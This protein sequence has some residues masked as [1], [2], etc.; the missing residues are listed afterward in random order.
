MSEELA[1]GHVSVGGDTRQ[2]A[3]DIRSFFARTEK[4]SGTS[5]Q[6]AGNAFGSK[7]SQG[8][9]SDRRGQ[10][11]GDKF[12]RGFVRGVGRGLK[13][14]AATFLIV[15][16]ATRGV[17]R[18][19][20]GIA[21]G[22]TLATRA[23]RY[24][25][26]ALLAGSAG[27]RMIAGV[28]FAKLAGWLKTLSRLAGILARDVGR[29]AAMFTVL[30]AAARTLGTAMRVTRVIGMLTVG[31]AT[32]IG[33]ASTAG[34]A[35][36]AL[37]GAIATLGSAAAGI[38]VA[39][40]SAFG[41]ALAGM[42]L[43]LSGMGDAFKA[44]GKSASGGGSAAAS[45]AKQVA[46]AQKQLARAVDDEKE[47]QEDVSKAREDARKKL[48]SLDRQLRGA[49]T[50]EK[51]AKLDL[52]DAQAELAKGDFANGR[53][54]A[55][56][57][58]AVE[59]AELELQN[60][61]ADNAD[62]VKEAADMRSKGVEGSDEVTAAQKRLYQATEATKEAQDAL[63]EARKPQDSGGGGT[64]PQ[65]EAMAKLSGN[66]QAF[67]RSIMAVAPAWNAMKKSVQDKLFAGL[68]ERVQPLA[69]NW[70]PRLG[71][72]LGVVT[73]GFNASAIKIADWLNTAQ[74]I[75]LT[76]TWLGTSSV[77]A[78]QFGRALGGITPGL[79]AIG[80]GAGQ[81]FE[82]MTRGLADS[83][84]Q[85]G[86][87]LVK[88]QETGQIKQFFL[89]AFNQTKQTIQNISAIVGPLISLFMELGKRSSAALAP[90]LR[91]VGQAI[92]QATPGLIAMADR[93]MPA[94]SQAM[95]NLAPII[96]AVVHAF[97]P[98]ANIMAI[99]LPHI[100]TLL[101][102]LGPMVPYLLGIVMAVKVLV[103]VYTLWNAAMGAASIAQ[104]IFFAA[105]RRSTAGLQGNLI[106]LAAHRA[107]MLT[108]AIASSIFGA[109]LAVATSPIT[110]IIVAIGALVAGI[111]L[112]YKKNETFRNIVQGAWN[113]IKA[114]IGAVWNWLQTS[115][116]PIFM[117]A[118]KMIGSIMSWLWK[119][120]MLPAWTGIKFAFQ[121]WWA[122]VSVIFKIFQVIIKAVG[123]VIMW[124]WRNVVSPAFTGIK[125]AIQ[126]WWAYAQII[127]KVF[128][129]ALK[130][131]G[132]VI[133]WL[134]RNV[135]MPAFRGIGAALSAVWNGVLK[136]IWDAFKQAM[137]VVGAA[138]M[139]LWNNAIKPAWDNIKNA[140]TVVWNVVKPIFENIGKG[141]Q[142]MGQIAARVGDAMRNAFDGVVDVIKAPLHA[143]GGLL[144]KMPGSILG[145]DIPGASSIK[146]W[147]ETLQA[148]RAGGP[149]EAG[150]FVVNARASQK[151]RGILSA[152][153]GQRIR[154][155][156]SGTS[157]SI[158]ARNAQGAA[159][160]RVSNGET[161]FAPGLA[162][163]FA[164]QLGAING[165]AT[166]GA[167][168]AAGGKI[169]PYGL[170]PGSSRRGAGQFPEWV[171]KLSSKF[172]VEPSTYAGHQETDRNE[173]G[174][175]PNP[176]R[177]NRGI[178]WGGPI[179]AM[180]KFAQ[181]LFSM[182]PK[183][184]QLEQIIWQNPNTGQKIGWAGR[185]PDKN[186]SYFA[187]NYAGH[188]DH[189]HSR[190]SGALGE[191]PKPDHVTD[192]PGVDDPVWT[193]DGADGSTGS[194][195][196]GGTDIINAEPFDEIKTTRDLF[197]TWGK[198]TGES[199]FDIF[200]PSQFSDLDPVSLYK[201]YTLQ[202]D[203]SNASGTD[204]NSL[205]P[206]SADS[207]AKAKYKKDL[208]KLIKDRETRRITPEQYKELKQKLD[209]QYRADNKDVNVTS[210]IDGT[211][212]DGLD[213]GKATENVP[214]VAGS[215]GSG[216]PTGRKGRANY[217]ADTI[218]AVKS[219]RL[220]RKAAEIA[221]ATQLV[222]TGI[223]MYANN[224][225]PESL[226][227]PHDAVGSDNDSIGL[228]Q[229]RSQ[230]WGTVAQRMSAFESSKLFLGAM[231]RKFPNWQSMDPGAV[232]QGVQVSAFPD[233]YATKMDEARQ[234]LIGKFDRGGV[235]PPG[236][237]LVE[238][239][240]GRYEQ[241][242]VFTPDQWDILQ[243][244]PSGGGQS[245]DARVLI[246]K[247]VVQDWRQAQRELKALGNRQQLRYSRSHTK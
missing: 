98:W 31:L 218:A 57:V 113:G 184:P 168:L 82:P 45:N 126:V 230:G 99:L 28:G 127:F 245:I 186:F 136:P 152:M 66:A 185:S 155:A 207:A 181:Y 225:V 179:E 30:S 61:Q 40:L 78:G 58:L 76:S 222:E 48:Q 143:L 176:G 187:S 2:L 175:A 32:L 198:I 70:I 39:G 79:V 236:I 156:G 145:V 125:F 94:L 124:L 172:G 148:L 10:E 208:K 171:R 80:A 192:V 14:L 13:G 177:Q 243:D 174:Y 95:T 54:R 219:M 229:Q 227:F 118:L 20:E 150:G 154:G 7:F 141:F 51:E 137:D 23:F 202:G 50:S 59:R 213:M 62:L 182:A 234:L 183:W 149:I 120:V 153:G 210:S 37:A 244:L 166:P 108:G 85:L 160:A 163:A 64:D 121:L 29:A 224:A 72:A 188:Q 211:G 119:N 36:V 25:S 228:Y 16:T 180:Q 165:G 84:T 123:A 38:G 12:G 201:R 191:E 93:I 44:M 197:G 27:L 96:P 214:E 164:G 56:A 116:F 173:P 88:A 46:A 237:S 1:S 77:M 159:V 239:R 73:S 100:A 105:T 170:P 49:A 21:R 221:L 209:D 247:L 8:M 69:D 112:L 22:L 223:K 92:T 18:H 131:V 15:G 200:V 217:I 138:V 240:L 151:H 110:W 104:G 162:A 140:I 203:G 194:S 53:E 55:R 216:K 130:A 206:N 226:K 87:W 122:Y 133:G 4:E 195:V 109:A 107:A 212:T 142:V 9:G 34:P 19:I 91:S 52:L 146:S 26:V 147:G 89:D 161:Y 11:E 132:A 242:A 158:V 71:M 42:K 74:G 75:Q 17:V 111:V 6:R 193:Q 232:A 47:A 169:E 135:A 167:A 231:V 102:K 144:A 238:N 246:D 233:K 41:A 97:T 5:G 117:S 67:V 106:A 128:Q 43:G 190:Q 101:V 241:A 33:L 24:F 65:A 215:A 129:I 157:D 114:A 235:V 134:W 178:D 90:G 63:N 205:E 60:V 86:N 3:R 220:P 81:A 35:I 83:A 139:W 199:L 204:D 103:G 115:V 68:A 189:V 196:D